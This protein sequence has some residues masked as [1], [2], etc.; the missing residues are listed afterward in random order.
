MSRRDV[1]G[2]LAAA[3]AGGLVFR[4]TDAAADCPNIVL[5]I[6]A[7]QKAQS[8][9]TSAKSDYNGHKHDALLAVQGALTQLGYCVQS[10]QCK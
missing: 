8:D 1:A 4:S 10:P 3:V 9:L 2:S 7:L 5:A 6:Q